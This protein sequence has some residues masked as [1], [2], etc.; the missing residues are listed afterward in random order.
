MKAIHWRLIIIGAVIAATVYLVWPRKTGDYINLNLGLDLRGG[1]HLLMQV[2]TDDA[3]R[4]ESDVIA[5]RIGERLRSEGFPEAR[6]VPGELGEI[7]FTDIPAERL[8]DAKAL[9]EEQISG[10]WSV[11]RG[12]NAI[13]ARMPNGDMDALRD[14]AVRQVLNTIGNRIDALGVAEP[15]LQRVGGG[16]GDRIL[17]QLPGRPRPSSSSAWPTTAR[18]TRRRSAA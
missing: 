12:G 9:I 8:A 2:I 4:A 14:Q 18:P 3:I 6:A 15:Q 7:R 10:G 13:V 11:S 1:S 17:L 5:T 16:S